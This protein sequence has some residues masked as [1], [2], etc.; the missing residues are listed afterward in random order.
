LRYVQAILKKNADG[1][2][3]WNDS[4]N[5]SII[6]RL[7]QSKVVMDPTIGLY[8]MVLRSVDDDITA[9]EPAF[10]TLPQ[11]LQSL[12]EHI[13]VPA[14]RAKALK[15][16]LEGMKALVKVLRDKGVTIVAGTDMGF[17]GYSLHRELELYVESGLTPLEAIRTATIVPARVMGVE[18]RYGSV[19]EGKVADLVIID[20]NVLE[21]IRNVRR[22]EWVVKDGVLYDPVQLK[23]MA[24]F[25]VKRK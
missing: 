4:A 19:T 17:P 13:G 14:E 25:G 7:A 5:A 1:S 18:G 15:P 23:T 20:G 2:I 8:E 24:G 22:I 9:I 6:S 21:N 3:D 12:F 16:R 11:P 10:R